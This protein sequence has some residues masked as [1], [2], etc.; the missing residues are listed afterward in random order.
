[1][2]EADNVV[3]MPA[4]SG[5]AAGTA[6]TVG[7]AGTAHDA[8]SSAI[9]AVMARV[10]GAWFAWRAWRRERDDLRALCALDD[11]TLRDLGLGRDDVG[12]LARRHDAR[13]AD[14]PRAQ[15]AQSSWIT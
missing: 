3:P 7:T 9:A 14:R 4:R 5:D 8:R 2:M 1:M 10:R 15:R 13:G 6:R 11:R 12:A